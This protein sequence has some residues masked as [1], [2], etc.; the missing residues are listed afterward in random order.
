MNTNARQLTKGLQSAYNDAKASDIFLEYYEAL[1]ISRGYIGADDFL[2]EPS[3]APCA[4]NLLLGSFSWND[5]PQGFAYWYGIYS[6]LLK[7]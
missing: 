4:A 2:G 7:K 1:Q 3:A 6:N 5:T